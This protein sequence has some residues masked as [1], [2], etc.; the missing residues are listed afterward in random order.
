MKGAWAFVKRTDPELWAEFEHA[1]V[2]GSPV[3]VAGVSKPHGFE[4]TWDWSFHFGL[5]TID[6][7]PTIYTR[8]NKQGETLMVLAIPRGYAR[9]NWRFSGAE[10]THNGRDP[11]YGSWAYVCLGKASKRSPEAMAELIEYDADVWWHNE[12][13]VPG[14][15]REIHCLSR[16]KQAKLKI[17]QMIKKFNR[18]M[19]Y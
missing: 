16:G 8:Q 19:T 3:D 6:G 5:P 4:K 14:A 9:Y 15:E 17:N 12:I 7:H 13:M 18:P 11:I 2:N 1:A 10:S